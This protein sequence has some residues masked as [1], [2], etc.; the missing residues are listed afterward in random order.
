MSTVKILQGILKGGEAETD[1][2]F[3]YHQFL[4]V[5]YAKPPVGE[6]R[7]K[8]PQ[9]PESWEGIRDAT[10]IT[11]SNVSCQIDFKTRN[12]IGSEDCLYL[13]VYTP[14][15]PTPVNEKLPVMVFIHGGG[16]RGKNGILKDDAGPDFM[17][18]SNVVIVTINYRLS[19]FGFLSLDI[20]EAAGNMGLK[21]QVKALE[22]VNKNIEY[23]NGDSNN[24][25]V[26]GSSAGATSSEYLLF[27]PTAK[28]LY[29]KAILQSGSAFNFY[30]LNKNPKKTAEELLNNLDYKGSR[31]NVHEI[32]EYLLKVSAED[33]VYACTNASP[34]YDP[35]KLNFGFVP[36]I[37]N[38]YGNGEAFLTTSPVNLIKQG[39]FNKVP[40]IKG[41]SNKEASL[42]NMLGS[43]SVQEL[44]NN[45]N[46]VDCFPF[47]FDSKDH[48]LFKNKFHEAYVDNNTTA[49]DLYEMALDFFS[50]LDFISGIWISGKFLANAGF[51]L[52]MYEFSYV[53]D[54]NLSQIFKM[55]LN[56]A[57]HTDECG[58]LFSSQLGKLVGSS[59]ENDSFIKKV[60]VKLWTDFAKTRPDCRC[61]P[62][63]IPTQGFLRGRNSTWPVAIAWLI[64]LLSL[65]KTLSLVEE[66]VED[67]PIS[68]LEEDWLESPVR[69]ALRR[70]QTREWRV[71]K[72]IRM[73]FAS[74]ESCAGEMVDYWLQSL[75][76][77]SF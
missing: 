30:A 44:A 20:P 47:D 5:P 72:P 9:P 17:I 4:G 40:V 32:L 73:S 49:E 61:Y 64:S 50:D 29:H 43:N 24:V 27:S 26:F 10:K 34:N 56:G 71:L 58:Y 22:W 70:V 63:S 54:L 52:Y 45:K 68:E 1:N 15:L 18:E 14:E 74:R 35:K 3:K 57:G 33:L 7:F 38:D 16:F 36:I 23:F 31:D 67:T 2:G 37:E 65:W 77:I 53:G 75:P 41:F 59:N 46:F 62:L 76:G 28:G 21:D 11:E 42:R 66:V 13:N 19:V 51:P 48:N 55:T 25:T 8:S 69:A 12:F 39:K 6:L 60:M